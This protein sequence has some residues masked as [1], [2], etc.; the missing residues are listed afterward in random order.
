MSVK[1]PTLPCNQMKSYDDTYLSVFGAIRLQLAVIEHIPIDII[2]L[3]KKF[4]YGNKYEYR[5]IIYDSFTYRDNI[6]CCKLIKYVTCCGYCCFNK[7][8]HINTKYVRSQDDIIFMENIKDIQRQQSLF[9]VCFAS[10]PCIKSCFNDIG[11]IKIWFW[12]KQKYGEDQILYLKGI[13]NSFDVFDHITHTLQQIHIPWY[14]LP[15]T[16]GPC[17]QTITS[18]DTKDF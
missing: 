1:N 10:L 11:I 2:K 5:T 16:G 4:C 6:K 15:R 7:D 8:I 18:C 14:K 9:D 13:R 12:T 17:R 3:I